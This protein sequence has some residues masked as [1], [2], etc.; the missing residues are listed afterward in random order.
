LDAK[1]APQGVVIA[2]EFTTCEKR[3]I[4]VWD[5]LGSRLEVTG[6]RLVQPLDHY[7]RARLRAA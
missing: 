3:G 7:L 2:S 5:Y 6:H 1:N 4:A